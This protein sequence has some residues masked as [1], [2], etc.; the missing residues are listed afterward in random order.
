MLS[1]DEQLSARDAHRLVIEALQAIH[2][3]RRAIFVMHDMDEMPM[4]DISEAL[5]VPV[6]TAYSRLRLARNEF[7]SAVIRLKKRRA[8]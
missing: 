1:A 5:G 3:E 8:T 4:K 2:V 7:K 6:N